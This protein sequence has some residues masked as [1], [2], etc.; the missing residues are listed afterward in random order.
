ML[1]FQVNWPH[2]HS[3]L[4]N[5]SKVIWSRVLYI[6]NAKLSTLETIHPVIYNTLTILP[7]PLNTEMVIVGHNW[8]IVERNIIYS[9]AVK[10][11]YHTKSPQSA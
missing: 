1:T 2:R 3:G 7:T 6:Y 4:A 8:L 11:R 10:T 5:L 9:S